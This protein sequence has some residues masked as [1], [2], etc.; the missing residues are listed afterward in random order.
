MAKE[1]KPIM[2]TMQATCSTPTCPNYERTWEFEATVT[3]IEAEGIDAVYAV[4]GL[5]SK[6]I[7]ELEL[8]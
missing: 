1:P 2:A 4:C 7:Y 3:R 8:I 6:P 5:C